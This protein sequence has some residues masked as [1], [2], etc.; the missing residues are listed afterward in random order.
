MPSNEQAM[1]WI[2]AISKKGV[3]YWTY[4]DENRWIKPIF[5]LII[6][7]KADCAVRM[8]MMHEF[9]I[10]LKLKKYTDSRYKD[11]QI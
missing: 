5:N 4:E 9:Q 10:F 2:L 8:I 1:I 6:G 7:M 3:S 11:Y